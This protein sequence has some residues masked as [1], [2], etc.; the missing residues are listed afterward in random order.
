MKFNLLGK[1]S[2]SKEFANCR[3]SLIVDEI[4]PLSESCTDCSAA[5][6]RYDTA[7]QLQQLTGYVFDIVSGKST[8]REIY[9]KLDPDTD[10]SDTFREWLHEFFPGIGAMEKEMID[11]LRFVKDM[12]ESV[13]EWFIKHANRKIQAYEK[14]LGDCAGQ[15][16]KRITL[17]RIGSQK[18]GTP[19][20]PVEVSLCSGE[21]EGV[22]TT[23]KVRDSSINAVAKEID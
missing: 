14:L 8:T 22:K 9:E 12:Q 5:A 10:M 23:K 2:K 6:K 15:G 18:D 21:L 11:N 3:D 7:L 16:L 4:S 1:N 13:A 17:E 20:K 19:K